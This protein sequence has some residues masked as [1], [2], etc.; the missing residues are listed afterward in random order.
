LL[1]SEARPCA[2]RCRKP[3]AVGSLRGTVL[4]TLTGNGMDGPNGIA[5]DGE[6][7]LVTNSNTPTGISLWK[8]TDLSPLGTLSFADGTSMFGACSDGI[9][10]WLTLHGS[11]QLVRF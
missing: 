2:R 6:R 7:V 4:A 8:A 3:R 10:F 5:F 9:N 1:Q 11:D